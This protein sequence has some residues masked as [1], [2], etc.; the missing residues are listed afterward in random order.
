MEIVELTSKNGC[1]EYCDTRSQLQR[2]IYGRSSEAFKRGDERRDAI[3]SIE[4]FEA[5]R[6]QMRKRF[7]NLIAGLPSNDTSLNPVITGEVVCDGFRIE[8]VIFESR[9]KNY[10]TAN[11]YLPEGQAERTGAVLFLCG[12]SEEGKQY[13]A[14]QRVCQYLVQAG[15]VVLAQDPIGQGERFSYYEKEI[16]RAKIN[17]CVPDHDHAGF[18]CLFLG[19]SLARYFIHDAMRG[20]DY[21]CTRDEVDSS[22][23]GVTG[24]SG[25][26]T[27][28]VMLMVCDERI[29]AAAPANFV[30]NRESYLYAGGAQDSEQLWPGY[31]ALGFDHEDLLLCMTPKPVCVN[32]VTYDFFPI[33][34]TRRTV[35]RVKRFWEMYRKEKNIQLHE[36]ASVHDYTEKLAIKAAEFFAT[37][38]KEEN[39]DGSQFSIRPLPIEKLW[40]TATGQIKA[41][42]E[43]ACFVYEENQKRLEELAAIRHANS[44]KKRDEEIQVWLKKKVFYERK[45]CD[46]NLR[47]FHLGELFDLEVQRCLWWAQEGLYSH[48]LSFKGPECAEKPPVTIAVWDGGTAALEDHLEWIKRE[49]SAGR[50]VLV[51]DVAGVGCLEPNPVSHFGVYE[52]YGTLRKF[53]DDLIWLDDS[54]PA[55]RIYDVLRTVEMIRE[56]PDLREDDIFVYGWG[57]YGLYGQLAAYMDDRIKKITVENGV[58]SF[59]EL[60]ATR[61]YDSFDL[62]SIILPGTLKYTDIDEINERLRCKG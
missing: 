50:V 9:P 14:Y 22:K 59:S 54:L 33:E 30:M 16:G 37:H 10:V 58:E 18:Q 25:G 49:C 23:I 34:G 27:Q 8:K 13:P 21:L 47:L 3:R 28:T 2:F 40:C 53:A 48:A 44:E 12:H 41:D 55:L 19:D 32:A 38:F 42:F 39:V 11:L 43:E 60:V 56:F 61:Y 46:L 45:P 1:M 62:K 31:T 51:L 17:P 7:V 29:A 15:F 6:R 52:S 36:D 20:I 26:G 5:Y 4:E 57:K 24:S 35:G